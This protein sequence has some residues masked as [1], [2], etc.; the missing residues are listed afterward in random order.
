MSNPY[1]SPLDADD[2]AARAAGVR[3]V[4][5]ADDDGHPTAT[6]SSAIG[7]VDD[8]VAARLGRLALEADDHVVP[9]RVGRLRDVR[10]ARVRLAVGVAVH[11]ADDPEPLVLGRHLGTEELATVDRV[12]PRRRRRVRARHE[13]DHTDRARRRAARTPRAGSRR[14]R[15][16]SS[17][18]Y[19]SA[20]KARGAGRP[21]TG[22]H[23]TPGLAS[24]ARAD[25]HAARP[26]GGGAARRLEPGRQ[27]ARRSL[28]RPVGPVLRR[29]AD[30]QRRAGRV[31]RPGRAGVAVGG[32]V[33]FGPPAVLLV[34]RT[35]L[36]PRGLLARLPG[37][38]RRWARSW[39]RSAASS[40][41]ATT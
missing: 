13:P 14:A 15:G 34:P 40:C 37:R 3:R 24:T 8:P 18:A 16:R 26:G 20:G 31:R 1:S 33:G 6:G 25:R 10:R 2:Q 38:A 7:P 28:H 5:A 29:R 35:G 41:W 36:R 39:R 21:V 4:D 19:W 22:D 11:H 17:R 32:A 9:R 12:D 27:A 30:V 23:R